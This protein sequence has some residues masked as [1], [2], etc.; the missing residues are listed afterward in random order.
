[1]R[2][3]LAILWLTLWLGCNPTPPAHTEA[4]PSATP[5]PAKLV[6]NSPIQPAPEGYLVIKPGPDWWRQ[7]EGAELAK[8]VYLEPGTYKLD[9]ALMLVGDARIQGAGILHTRI[10][11]TSSRMALGFA[12]GGKVEL[13]HLTIEHQGDKPANVVDI[14]AESLTMMACA[15]RNGAAPED[16]L[17]AGN[18][19]VLRGKTKASLELCEFSGNRSCGVYQLGQSNVVAKHCQAFD[20]QL[21][22]WLG[23]ES[24]VL[25]IQQSEVYENARNGLD[26]AGGKLTS[27]K[28]KCSQNAATGILATEETSA[29]L[30]ENECSHNGQHGIQI[31][32]GYQLVGNTCSHNAEL[33]INL[34]GDQTGLVK[35]NQCQQNALHGIEVGEQATPELTGNRL[36]KNTIAGLSYYQ[37]AAGKA[38]GNVISDNGRA[39]IVIEAPANPELGENTLSGAV[40]RTQP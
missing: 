8:G 11:S 17:E 36:V 32:G 34:D 24:S 38:S 21:S 2:R 30:H 22:G 15:L 13:S 31:G 6:Q 7:L 14:E 27:T 40:E 35:G 37:Q 5:S 23:D 4:T 19:L 3:Y 26:W 12:Q 28:T 33:G 9:Q 1:M 25:D 39:A 10:V 18:G 20:N 29:T 16:T